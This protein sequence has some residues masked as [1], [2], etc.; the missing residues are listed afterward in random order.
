MNYQK[1]IVNVI[2]LI[3]IVVLAGLVGYFYAKDTALA[4]AAAPQTE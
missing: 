1:G 3:V 2:L 4:P